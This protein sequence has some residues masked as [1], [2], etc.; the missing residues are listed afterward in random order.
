MVINE[1]T[2]QECNELLAR[3]SF[4]RLGCSLNNQPYIVPIYF[5]YESDYVYVLSTV[6]QKIEWMRTN[7]KVCLQVDEIMT[8][9]RWLSVIAN[10]QY[11][12]LS[13]S[14]YPEQR[15][16]ARE[17][18]ERRPQWWRTAMAERQLKSGRDL[19]APLLF[20][21]RIDCLTGLRADD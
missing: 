1:L 3:A 11:E 6:G 17:L 20:R 5:V 10:G 9:S 8:N 7:P 18:L 19:I 2:E 21:M 12:E 14:Q 13:E 4:G 15:A 16:H